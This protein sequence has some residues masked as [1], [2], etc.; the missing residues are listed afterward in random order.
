M[1][2]KDFESIYS[3]EADPW[4][5]KDAMDGRYTRALEILRKHTPYTSILELG[6]GMGAFTNRLTEFTK[7]IKGYDISETAIKRASERFPHISFSVKDAT[8]CSWEPVDLIV[9]NDMLYY[10][11]I[12][13]VKKVMK[14][15]SESCNRCFMQSN[16]SDTHLDLDEFIYYGKK[17]FK[18]TYLEAMPGRAYA[19]LDKR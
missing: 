16:I 10:M 7:D 18:L 8:S 4:G 15:I 12:I 17:Y 13:D 19:Y 5:V 1:G 14:L 9:H 6:C 2:L 11:V 3:G